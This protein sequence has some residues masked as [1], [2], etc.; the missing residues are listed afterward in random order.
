M[1][2]AVAVIAFLVLPTQAHQGRSDKHHESAAQTQPASIRAISQPAP[3]IQ[4][5]RAEQ[6]PQ[7]WID[8]FGSSGP[9]DWALVI[10]GVIAAWAALKTLKAIL[11]QVESN[12]TAADATKRSAD[13]AKSALTLSAQQ[14]EL[15]NKSLDISRT[16]AEAAKKSAESGERMLGFMHEQTRA[17]IKS[18]DAAGRSADVAGRALVSSHRAYM[19]VSSAKVLHFGP[20]HALLASVELYN[21]GR[22]PATLLQVTCTLVTDQPLDET[23]DHSQW[24]ICNGVVGPGQSMN[25]DNNFNGDPRISAE[26][27]IKV[28]AGTFQ[29][30]F[31]GV[32]RYRDGFEDTPVRET[33]FGLTFRHGTRRFV[34]SDVPGYNYAT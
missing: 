4:G 24:R 7:P 20:N 23:A 17:A 22:L 15:A 2:R 27:W 25:S 12:E 28:L 19:N 14:I 30:H 16:A 34:I 8:W 32:F 29:V 6:K 11:R 1:F 5:R 9:A 18:A 10:V 13:I 31:Y 33:G 26:E 21:S 3:A